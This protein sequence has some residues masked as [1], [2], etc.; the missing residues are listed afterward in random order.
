MVV[1]DGNLA[2]S[3]GGTLLKEGQ[4]AGTTGFANLQLQGHQSDP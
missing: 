3:L 2:T 4:H 1:T